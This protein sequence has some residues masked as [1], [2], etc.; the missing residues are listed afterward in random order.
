MTT[1]DSGA[2]SLP[3]VDARNTYEERLTR[4]WADVLDRPDISVLDSFFDVGGNSM[5]ALR[6]VSR[7]RA[8]LGV[9]LPVRLIF[10]FPTVAALAPAVA[11]AMADAGRGRPPVTPGPH[12]QFSPLSFDQQ[13]LWVIDRIRPG[14]SAYTLHGRRLLRGPLRADDLAASLSVV[15]RRHEAL[16]SRFPVVDGRP[17][18]VVDMPCAVPL[19]VEDMRDAT[20]DRPTAWRRAH[21]VADDEARHPFDLTTGPVLRCRL[22]RLSE[23]EHL[24]MVTMHH[25]VSDAWSVHLMLTELVE[26]YRVRGQESLAELAELPVQYR[27]V[28]RWQREWLT[29]ERLRVELDRFVEHLDG[30]PTLIELPASHPRWEAGEEGARVAHPLSDADAEC[31]RCVCRR[32]GLT[33]FMALLATTAL[34]LH[35]WTGEDGVVV[36]VPMA[37]R[38][39]PETDHLIGFFVNVVPVAVRVGSAE[40]V[41]ELLDLARAAALDAYTRRDVPFDLLVERLAPARD[42]TRTPV[43]QVALNMLDEGRQDQ[44]VDGLEVEAVGQPVLASKFDLTVNAVEAEGTWTLDLDF[45]PQ[46]YPQELVGRFAAEIVSLLRTAADGP[47]TAIASVSVPPSPYPEPRRAADPAGAGSWASAAGLGRG[48]RCVLLVPDPQLQDALTQAGLTVLSPPPALSA[49]Q[50][51]LAWLETT[52]AE[53]ICLSAPQLR[54]VAATD[55]GHLQTRVLL[56]EGSAPEPGDLA[57]ALRLAPH[58]A[59]HGLLRHGE[60]VLALFPGEPKELERARPRALVPP[61]GPILTVRAGDGEPC[62]LVVRGEIVAEL[63]DG[64]TLATGLAGRRLPDGGLEVDGPLARPALRAGARV[65]AD[66]VERA[67]RRHPSVTDAVVKVCDTVIAAVSVREPTTADELRQFLLG[68]LPDVAVPERIAVLSTLPLELLGGVDVVAALSSVPD[69]SD[70]A[71]EA[72]YVAA[73]TPLERWLCALFAELLGSERVGIHDAFF[74]LNGFSLLA[75]QLAARIEERYHIELPLREVFESPSVAGLAQVILRRQAESVG[76]G[77]LDALL[78][79]LP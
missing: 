69:A 76:D 54:R 32:H 67:L 14:S 9:D 65:R 73:R 40:T 27:D 46:V 47:D 35:R 43:F 29:K 5:L 30:V 61:A 6:L 24:L 50:E 25:I 42:L 15:V 45:N 53:A 41:A 2:L 39:S 56:L 20:G 37:G 59:C 72:Q 44:Y 13:R 60:R 23:Q 48:V 12:S 4:V 18:Q 71:G 28:A 52:G 10:E 66:E 16:R 36:G 17:V 26:L 11:A 49:D 62:D 79:S 78:S 1:G 7:I 19:P 58:A 57:A 77:V 34:V 64:S 63:D 75:T 51:L 55:E 22:L 74:D 38:G 70:T 33:P 21:E 8:E 68:R 31:L 3:F